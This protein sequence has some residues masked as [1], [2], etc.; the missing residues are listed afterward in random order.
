MNNSDTIKVSVIMP[1]Y[2]AY[3]YLRPAVDS[4]LDQTL[5]EI[6]LVC[7]DD[8]STDSSLEILKEYQ[9]LDERVRI[10]TENN[11]GPSI[12][13]NKGLARCRGK[14]VMFLDADDF[15]E[16]TLLESLYGLAEEHELDIAVA[17]Y[18]IYNS[19]KAKFEHRIPADHEDVL[20]DGVVTS[21]NEHPDVIFSSV[22]NYVWNKLFSRDFLI[23][24]NVSFPEDIRVFEDV[25]FVMTAMAM[26][27]RVAKLDRVL[28]HHRIYSDQHKNKLFKKYYM[29]VPVLYKS[30]KE[31]LM[32][33]GVYAPL[34]VSF[35]NY[36]TSRC[37]KIY[38]MLWKDAKEQMWNS[39]HT[40]YATVLG[41]DKANPE[42]FESDE[43]RDFTASVLMYDFTLNERRSDKGLK[44][45]VGRVRQRLNQLAARDKFRKFF[46]GIFGTRKKK[47]TKKEE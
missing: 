34:S 44:V 6:E 16:P 33:N 21:K 46:A 1:I 37:Y 20:G 14:Y 43:V 3:D 41:W 35:L 9:K 47:K 24:K 17:S 40:E 27:T 29:Q 42:D 22:S 5:R 31:F 11:A 2:N 7:I 38:N 10:I 19:R 32:H 18:D 25:Y 4:V 30:V 23:Q 8:G 45:E 15:Y 26:A 13:R 36:S 28:V 39:L 12:A